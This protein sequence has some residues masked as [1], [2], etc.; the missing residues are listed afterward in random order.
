VETFFERPIALRRQ[1]PELF[2]A[3]AAFFNMDPTTSE[4]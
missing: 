2:D 3:M 1:H 4:T